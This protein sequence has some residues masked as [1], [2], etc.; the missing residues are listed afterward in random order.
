M[1]INKKMTCMQNSGI[2]NQGHEPIVRDMNSL[3]KPLTLVYINILIR[4][5]K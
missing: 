4:L 1:E 2:N 3:F 5:M